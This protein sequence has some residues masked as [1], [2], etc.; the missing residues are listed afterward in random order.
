M[1]ERAECGG[2]ISDQ[3]SECGLKNFFG[4]KAVKG[5]SWRQSAPKPCG[6]IAPWKSSAPS[7]PFDLCALQ[8]SLHL[9][10]S[11]RP[12]AAP[13]LK[14]NFLLRVPGAPLVRRSQTKSA[15]LGKG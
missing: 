13:R 7:T 12:P 5:W 11:Y 10:K 1:V 8:Q 6:H 3:K 4:L 15:E 2:I 9:R 14:V